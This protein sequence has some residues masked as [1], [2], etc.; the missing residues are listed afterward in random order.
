MKIFWDFFENLNGENFGSKK[1]LIEKKWPK[2]NM[3][4]IFAEMF[5]FFFSIFFDFGKK[6]VDFFKKIDPEKRYF[7]FPPPMLIQNFP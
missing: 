2:K 3:A 7:D 5:D 4:K 6:I 1:N